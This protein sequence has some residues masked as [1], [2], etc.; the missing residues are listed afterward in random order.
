MYPCA[1][2]C[3]VL[4]VHAAYLFIYLFI[5]YKARNTGLSL[6]EFAT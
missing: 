1:T 6:F 5:D 4:H 2:F 3:L